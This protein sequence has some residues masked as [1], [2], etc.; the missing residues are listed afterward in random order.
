M[1]YYLIAGERSGDLHGGNLIKALASQDSN[2]AFRC[3][4]GEQ[5]QAA[6]AAL[7]VHYQE[8]AMMGFAEVLTNL[9]KLS[10][11]IQKCK[12][13]I[14]NYQPD[15]VILI[16]F[17]GFNLRIAS[18][19]KQRGIKV[20]YY[21]TPK[22]WAWNQGRAKKIKRLVDKMFVI[23][24]FE[25]DFYQKYDWDVDY[26]GNPV[27]DAVKSFMPDPQFKKINISGNARLIAVLPGSRKQE[28]LR[29]SSTL[30]K[31]FQENSHL[32]FAIAA[33]DTLPALLYDKLKNYKNV[34][35][36]YEQTYDLLSVADAAI[37][38]SGTATLET[39]LFKV[40]QV[41]V[42]KTSALNYAIGSRLVNVKYISLPN[43]IADKEVV[44]ELLQD[45]MTADTVVAELKKLIDDQSYRAQMLSRYEAIYQL[46][47]IGSASQNA[48]T[49]I[50][51]YLTEAKA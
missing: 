47:D 39:A 12:A 7:A 15:V 22:V 6:G 21:I 2:A 14:L 20:F 42:Y 1:K 16:D 19:L 28:L 4:G 48:A 46:L 49:L 36:I 3:F 37:V 13:D 50:T 45:K 38:T 33:V 29:V 11:L 32:H 34:S 30:T 40:P 26:V 9:G 8:L 17:G 44:R 18:F 35:L 51:K 25:K 41:V 31:V 23:L 43:L 10:R 5:M 24:P 27:L